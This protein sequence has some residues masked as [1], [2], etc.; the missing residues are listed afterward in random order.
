M[1]VP[2]PLPLQRYV[3]E[4]EVMRL[5]APE[6]RYVVTG[7]RDI[8][9]VLTVRADGRWELSK[10]TLYD[11]THLPCRTGVY[12][13]TASD[14]CKPLASMQGAFPVKPGA[15]MPTFDGCA[16]VDRAVLFVVGVEV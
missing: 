1:E 7:D 10:G 12:T 5:I 9:A 11:V 4:G 2:E 8:T 13:P 16:T 6:K 15:R 14:S 3:R